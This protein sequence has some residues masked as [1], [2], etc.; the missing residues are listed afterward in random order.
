MRLGMK[1]QCQRLASNIDCVARPFDPVLKREFSSFSE[2]TSKIVKN[3]WSSVMKFPMNSPFTFPKKMPRGQYPG[4]TV[5]ERF[6]GTSYCC[7]SD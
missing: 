1:D 3:L 5:A 7:K 2:M 4:S 6:Y